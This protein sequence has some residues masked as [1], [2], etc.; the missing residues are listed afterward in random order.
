MEDPPSSSQLW[1]S[2][3][4]VLH[5]PYE[6]VNVW[7]HLLPGLAFLVLGCGAPPRGTLPC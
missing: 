3:A 1:S 7:S 4:G 2:S 5:D 6:R